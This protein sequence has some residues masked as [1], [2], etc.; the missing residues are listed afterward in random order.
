MRTGLSRARRLKVAGATKRR[1]TATRTST[2]RFWPT[3][4]V[5][6]TIEINYL[7]TTVITSR[8]VTLLSKALTYSLVTIFFLRQFPSY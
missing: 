7:I 8:H 4:Q 5:A 6:D 3:L 1:V 2:R